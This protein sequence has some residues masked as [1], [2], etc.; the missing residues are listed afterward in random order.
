M[1][2]CSTPTSRRSERSKHPSRRVFRR[3]DVVGQEPGWYSKPNDGSKAHIEMRNNIAKFMDKLPKC[4]ARGILRPAERYQ[5]FHKGRFGS[6]ARQ[7]K[8]DRLSNRMAG[9]V[10]GR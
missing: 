6:P 10:A 3:D 2:S 5:F 7:R 4:R 9:T 1:T 8:R